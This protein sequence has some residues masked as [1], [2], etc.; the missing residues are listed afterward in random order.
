MKSALQGE[1]HQ[2]MVDESHHPS[3]VVDEFQHT[4]R[5]EPCSTSSHLVIR[6][7]GPQHPKLIT[8]NIN[9]TNIL[10]YTQRVEAHLTLLS[11][12][13][14]FFNG[15]L[16]SPARNMWREAI[17]KELRSMEELKVWDPVELNPA[18][19]LVGTTWVF[20]LKKDR[21]D[22]ILEHKACLCAQGFTQ[23]PGIDYSKAYGTTG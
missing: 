11:E 3:E 16:K 19:K 4:H 17:Q 8:G 7:I 9:Q 10:P 23:T 20:K 5:A 15:A 2:A 22:R 18:Y 1:G 14:R 13:P 21:Y 6:I 12:T